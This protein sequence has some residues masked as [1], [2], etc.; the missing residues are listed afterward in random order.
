MCWK[1][2]KTFKKKSIK[3]LQI[4]NSCELFLYV[5]IQN[6]RNKPVSEYNLVASQTT[7][8][9]VHKHMSKLSPP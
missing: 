8:R 2:Y 1:K 9:L 6:C 3:R 5:G 4:L 7:N